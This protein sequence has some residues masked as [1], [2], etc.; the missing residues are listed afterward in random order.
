VQVN[1]WRR[2]DPLMRK[3]AGGEL[4]AIVGRPHVVHGIYGNG[5]LN[6]GTHLVDLCRMFFGEVVGIRVL[7]PALRNASL[8]LAGDFDVACQLRF[9][10]GL[11]A[12]LQPLDFRHYREVGLDVWGDQGRLEIWNEGL[13]TRAFARHPHRALSEAQEVAIDE[14]KPLQSTVSEALYFL[15][16]NLALALDESVPLQSSG[17][18]AWRTAAVVDSIRHSAAAG[19]VV[20]RAV[21]YDRPDA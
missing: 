6:N 1:L 21:C 13:V 3:L 17:A 9:A 11:T 7:G 15:Y 18:S 20:E 16:D 8:P 10:D 19:S 2:C 14:P 5:L 12:V 4:R